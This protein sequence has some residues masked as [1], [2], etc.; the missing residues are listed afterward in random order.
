MTLKATLQK[1]QAASLA[2]I[3][4]EAAAIMAK[5]KAELAASGILEMARGRGQ[6]APDFVLRDWQDNLFESA[7]ILAGG[8][9]VLTFYRG[10]W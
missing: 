2:R 3:P 6:T 8:P 4:A 5:T 1:M 10:S 7:E 9:L